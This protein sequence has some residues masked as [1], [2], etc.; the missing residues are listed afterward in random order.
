MN[1]LSKSTAAAIFVA[2]TLLGSTAWAAAKGSAENGSPSV[3]EELLEILR[4][5]GSISDDKYEELRVRAQQEET[6]RIDAAVERAA[7]KL[8]PVAAAGDGPTDWKVKW[9]N[10]FK[11]ERNDGAF[12]LKF[13][14]R[15]QNDWALIDMDN[16]LEEAIG[17]EGNGT[18]FRR[19]RIFFEGTVYERLIFKAQYDFANTGDGNTDFKDVW[20]GLK[21]LG[22]VGTV[23]VGHM[24]EPFSLEEQTS[25]KYLPFLERSLP[26]VFSPSRNTG[27]MAHN[28]A[29]D[30]RLL[31]QIGAFHDTNDSAFDFDD[32]SRWNVT[33]RV[34]GA[35]VYA[36]DGAK[37]VHVGAAYSHQFRG[38]NF[39]RRYRQRPEAHLAN[40]FVDTSGIP[41]DDADLLG[42][43]FATVLGP[44]FF[45]AEYMHS[46]VNGR[47]VDDTDFWGAYAEAGYFLTGEHRNY[48]LGNGRFG[49]V[50]PNRNFNPAN[51]DWGAFEIAARFSY[52]DLT[53]AFIDGGQMW[54]VTAGLNWYVFPN[55]R[56]M[57]NYIHSHVDNRR[58][59]ASEINGDADIA[60][61]RFQVD[62]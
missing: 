22:P 40:R 28:T 55:A 6:E 39:M 23:R 19:A 33:A 56:V 57:L 11:V 59:A 10:G 51:G 52:L 12:K 1:Q 54:D 49:R 61:I 42:L 60:Q 44:A 35:P 31:W 53:D 41:T 37:V 50:S 2:T 27:I 62:F 24:K 47:D 17:G 21:G 32:N 9:S 30:K 58:I 13:G 18:E 25:S 45:Q 36:E 3:A 48:E 46:W 14:G 43:E 8:P 34:A 20:M 29:F 4:E 38:D 16:E 5:A 26:N 15:I 7:A